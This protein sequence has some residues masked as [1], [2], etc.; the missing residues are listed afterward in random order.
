MLSLIRPVLSPANFHN[1]V[2]SGPGTTVVG[3]QGEQQPAGQHIPRAPVLV[4]LPSVHSPQ[5][6][7][8]ISCVQIEW[9]LIGARNRFP[10]RSGVECLK[11]PKVVSEFVKKLNVVVAGGRSCFIVCGDL[12]TLPHSSDVREVMEEVLHLKGALQLLWHSSGR[13]YLFSSTQV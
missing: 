9:L 4:C 3:H 7:M 2:C 11:P 6:S 10:R 5:G 8:D 12:N 1:V 13:L